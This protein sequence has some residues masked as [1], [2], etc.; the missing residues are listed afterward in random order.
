MTVTVTDNTFINHTSE[1]AAIGDL[2]GSSITRN[3]FE[4]NSTV[5]LW[6]SSVATT[7]T[8][9]TMR[10]NGGDGMFVTLGTTGLT[11]ERNLITTN[12]GEGVDV[13]T[14]SGVAL[15]DNEIT[16]NTSAGVYIRSSG[17]TLTTNTITGNGGPGVT[18]ASGA[19]AAALTG[20]VYGANGGVAIDLSTGSAASGDG[21]TAN[22]AAPPSCGTGAGTGNL[23]LDAPIIDDVDLIVTLS[24]TGRAC[25]NATVE[26]YRAVADGDSSDTSGA[27]DFGEG[28]ELLGTTTADGAGDWSLSGI[29][30]MAPTDVV[31]AVTI[32]SGRT[33]EFG[34]NVVVPVTAFVNSTGDGGDA[35]PGNGTCDTGGVNSEGDPEC[36]LRAAI[37]ETN[38]IATA[39]SIRFAIPTSDGGYN[40]AGA[41]PG[42]SSPPAPR[43]RSSPTP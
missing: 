39:D 27:Q 2:S 17:S 29:T 22:T 36:T 5:G 21:I 20:N 38:A 35:A 24:V 26:V 3:L 1:G 41:T 7:A 34:A 10:L 4:S 32:S 18:V 30:G 40:T 16:G 11:A 8:D 9:N 28:T 12:G 6:I 23:G 33:S 42:G 14:A 19:T 13:Y 43:C 31:S 37:E 25:A 15:T